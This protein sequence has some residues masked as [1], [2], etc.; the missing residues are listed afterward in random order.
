MKPF[1]LILAL[2]AFVYASM[3][4]ANAATKLNSVK[5]TKLGIPYSLEYIEK[6]S[7]QIKKQ[8][9][10]GDLVIFN[11]SGATPTVYRTYDWE[12]RFVPQDYNGN[13]TYLFSTNAAYSAWRYTTDYNELWLGDT[14]SPTPGTYTIY[15]QNVSGVGGTYESGV[16]FTNANGQGDSV[17][18]GDVSTGQRDI[19][20]SNVYVDGTN[21]IEIVVN[22]TQF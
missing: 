15:I 1:K 4:T 14:V 5:P 8:K 6:H 13:S 2:V 22:K 16:G 11:E 20:L 10:Y 7:T 19:V 21:P 12:V 9:S 17:W 18:S 3:Y